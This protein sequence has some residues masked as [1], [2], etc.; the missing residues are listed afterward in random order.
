[1]QYF[2]EDKAKKVK[3]FE[4]FNSKFFSTICKRRDDV[5]ESRKIARMSLRLKAALKAIIVWENVETT[6][7][8]FQYNLP[9]V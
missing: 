8:N 3:V 6:S 4:F 7:D 9:V 2:S 1:M 5:Q